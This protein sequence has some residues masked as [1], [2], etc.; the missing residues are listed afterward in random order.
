MKQGRRLTRK[1][2]PHPQKKNLQNQTQ[3]TTFGENPSYSENCC[4]S[5]RISGRWNANDP[6]GCSM[7]RNK[8]V[9][10]PKI[11]RT[12]VASGSFKHKLD[13]QKGNPPCQQL[14]KGIPCSAC[15]EPNLS[16]SKNE[17]VVQK[18]KNKE[19][20]ER[21][22]PDS[23]LVTKLLQMRLD[24]RTLNRAVFPYGQEWLLLC[25][26]AD[27][28]PCNEHGGAHTM[29]PPLWSLGTDQTESKGK[30]LN[31]EPQKALIMWKK[32]YPIYPPIWNCI[33]LQVWDHTK[34][35]NKWLESHTQELFASA[36]WANVIFVG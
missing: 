10:H 25:I 30:P 32:T 8:D 4:A 3:A 9:R 12:S 21:I 26:A 33:P 22:S 34:I 28:G 20:M 17:E 31:K 14:Q 2:S 36:F 29:T 1:P 27:A 35:T 13:L 7:R 6:A 11:N 19:Q 5:A 16:N 18:R 23:F 15:M 24:N